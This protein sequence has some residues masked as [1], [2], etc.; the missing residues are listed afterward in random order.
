MG[1]LTKYNRK[2]PLLFEKEKNLLK[3]ALRDQKIEKIEHIG[4]TSIERCDTLGT[5]D[6]LI[7]VRSFLDFVTIKNVLVKKGYQYI[8]NKS[9]DLKDMFFIRRDEK[10]QIIASFHL[11]EYA[12]KLYQEYL[13]F[14]FYVKEGRNALTYNKIREDILEK[15]QG[16]L[17][18]YQKEKA[19]YIRYVIDNFCVTSG[20]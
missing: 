12:S 15:Y 10:N 16:D 19:E 20:S 18:Q 6:V 9:D 11:V 1:R 13:L 8:A 17:K 5:I 7:S 14:A 2:W 3:K 4:A